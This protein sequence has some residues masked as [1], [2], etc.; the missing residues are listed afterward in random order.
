MT[1]LDNILTP[2]R[3]QDKRDLEILGELFQKKDIESKTEL[4]GEQVVLINQ[5]RAISKMLKW[6]SLNEC[7]SDFMTLQVSKDRKGRAE[8]I[9]GFKSERENTINK[10]GGFFSGIKDRIMGK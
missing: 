3:N 8:F 6:D 1:E 5:K 10:S 4:T 9:D 2:A 7:L